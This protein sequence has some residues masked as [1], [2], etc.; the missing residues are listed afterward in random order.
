ME[1]KNLLSIHE[2]IY[3]TC[4]FNLR[5]LANIR[6]IFPILLWGFHSFNAKVRLFNK[7]LVLF[8]DM[9]AVLGWLFCYDIRFYEMDVQNAEAVAIVSVIVV[10]ACSIYHRESI[11]ELFS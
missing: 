4:R 8:I 7:L 2:F 11:S 5:G 9:I 10:V 3:N 1:R 6:V